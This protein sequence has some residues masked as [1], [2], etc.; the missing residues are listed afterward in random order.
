MLKVSKKYCTESRGFL[1][2]SIK[3][4][5]KK[6]KTNVTPEKYDTTSANQKP[7][8]HKFAPL[9]PSQQEERA[10]QHEPACFGTA[11]LSLALPVTFGHTTACRTPALD[12]SAATHFTM[13]KCSAPCSTVLRHSPSSWATVVHCSALMSKALKSSKKQ[14][15]HSFSCPPT[16][17]APP[18]NSPN[19]T[20]ALG[21]SRILHA[22]HKSRVQD[23]P[24]A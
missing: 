20:H 7:G 9:V 8:V 4:K 21:Q 12:F 22:R 13:K 17:P 2:E 6:N 11:V 23:P 18:T 19:I 10:N 1:S 24:P 3:T 5:T 15:I 14:P 16:Q